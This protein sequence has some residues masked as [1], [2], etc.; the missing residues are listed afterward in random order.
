MTGHTYE[1]IRAG[2]SW[3]SAPAGGPHR[4]CG[5]RAVAHAPQASPLLATNSA[6]S[7]REWVVSWTTR[8]E[9]SLPTASA[10]AR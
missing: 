5:S 10:T 3:P 7:H 1:H 4:H 8:A 6:A 9:T 2:G